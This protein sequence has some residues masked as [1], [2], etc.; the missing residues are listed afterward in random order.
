M[1]HSRCGACSGAALI[2]VNTVCSEYEYKMNA[3][4][5]CLWVGGTGK[6]YGD[7]ESYTKDQGHI[8]VRQQGMVK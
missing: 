4:T 2:Q 8:N 1:P 3:L 6:L 7:K 5:A